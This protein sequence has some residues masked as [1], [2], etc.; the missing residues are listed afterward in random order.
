M[1][2]VKPQ[3]LRRGRKTVAG[4]DFFHGHAI[5]QKC[6]SRV[7]VGPRHGHG[8]DTALFASGAWNRRMKRRGELHRVQT[9]PGASRG[10]NW[11]SYH[12][13]R[14]WAIKPRSA[15]LIRSSQTDTESTTISKLPTKIGEEP[16]RH[17][18]MPADMP[19]LFKAFSQA[20]A[21]TDLTNCDSV[22]VIPDG[23]IARCVGWLSGSIIRIASESNSKSLTGISYT[24]KGNH[25]KQHCNLT[26]FD[27]KL[28]ARSLISGRS[29]NTS[30]I[31]RHANR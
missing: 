14:I 21:R 12:R 10:S 29:L 25:A 27:L 4:L 30:T 2:L 23:R 24:W 3:Q 1:K 9:S 8:Q 17:F 11:P 6:K 13:V 5:G 16:L 20:P 19:F 7:L 22:I 15:K 18:P 28:R 26:R 31:C